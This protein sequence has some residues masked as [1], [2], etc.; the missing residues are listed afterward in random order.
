VAD[1]V[2]R[3]SYTPEQ[4]KEDKER[5]W[6][7]W[8]TDRLRR[9]GI[10]AG[11][12]TADAD[13]SAA[14]L[15]NVTHIEWRTAPLSGQD[16]VFLT[17]VTHFNVLDVDSLPPNWG[18][19]AEGIHAGLSV[20]RA[21]FS[22]GE[23]VPLHLRWENVNATTP[24]AQGECNEPEPALEIQDSHH[25]VV[26]TIS[27]QHI[28]SGHGWGP[29]L[30]QKGKAQRTFF[31]LTTAPPTTPPYTTQV[32]ADLPGTGVYYLV[33]VWSP[34]VLDP[35]P[36]ETDNTPQIGNHS[37]SIGKVYA[38]ARSQPVRIEVAPLKSP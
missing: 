36:A 25:N 17:A 32:P 34:R 11:R 22:V 3:A 2:S 8:R 1:S 15:A 27:A 18:D 28:C 33:S 26:R 7:S 23:R 13:I 4:I 10:A 16:P 30:I 31:Q 19:S 20:D 24:L 38:T 12:V 9:C 21:S 35:P 29:F 5:E 37:G 14:T 6:P